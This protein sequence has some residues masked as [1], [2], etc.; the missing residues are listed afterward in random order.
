M[1][2]ILFFISIVSG[3]KIIDILDEIENGAKSLDKRT[4]FLFSV[5][6][7]FLMGPWLFY[8]LYHVPRCNDQFPVCDPSVG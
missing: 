5:Y 2:V 7:L 3:L 8:S 1:E 6:L 4:L